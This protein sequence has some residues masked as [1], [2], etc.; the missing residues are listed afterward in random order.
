MGLFRDLRFAIRTMRDRPGFA[1]PAICILAIGISANTT[2]FSILN[3]V[4]LRPLPYKHANRIAIVWEKRKDG[5]LTNGVT[6]A[7]YLDWRSRNRVFST[8]TAHDEAAFTLT[9]KGEPLRL[10][11]V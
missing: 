9:G 7:D 11:A 5:T 1:L 2:I 8:L 3:S 6:P 10:T 4:L